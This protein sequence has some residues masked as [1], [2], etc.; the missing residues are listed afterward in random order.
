MGADEQALQQVVMLLVV[1]RR[2]LT[3][4]LELLARQFPSLQVNDRGHGDGDPFLFVSPA[5]TTVVPRRP[6][7]GHVLALRF[8]LPSFVVIVRAGVD[9]IAEQVDEKATCPSW[10]TVARAGAIFIESFID[11]IS[12]ELLVDEPAEDLTHDLGFRFVD[13]EFTGTRVGAREVS[14]AV[15]R[16]RHPDA[17]LPCSKQSPAAATFG[18]LC[19]FVFG[20][21]AGHLQEHSFGGCVAEAVIQEDDLATGTLAPLR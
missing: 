6:C 17:T 11:L 9:G 13:D 7:R 14:V 1:A 21:D 4:E 15:R 18:D 19:A 5:A 8:D 20:E 12:G 2:A 3:I 10:L 16:F